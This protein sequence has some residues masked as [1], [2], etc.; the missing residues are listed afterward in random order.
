MSA[1]PEKP[2][3][4]DRNSLTSYFCFPRMPLWVQNRT[5]KRI[6]DGPLVTPGVSPV[7]SLSG[8][9]GIF[10]TSGH[11]RVAHLPLLPSIRLIPSPRLRRFT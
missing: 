10:P 6:E 9:S 7:S 3:K 8:V 2:D 4:A 1:P 5:P 11:S